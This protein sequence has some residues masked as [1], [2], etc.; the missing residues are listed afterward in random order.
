MLEFTKEF[1]TERQIEVL[2]ILHDFISSNAHMFSKEINDVL[3][4]L[5]LE[6]EKLEVRP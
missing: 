5:L 6:I 3:G 4:A 2:K 1:Y